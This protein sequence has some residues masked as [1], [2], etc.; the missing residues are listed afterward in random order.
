MAISQSLRSDERMDL[1]SD[2]VLIKGLLPF[3]TLQD[4]TQTVSLLSKRWNRILKTDAVW[5]KHDRTPA[6]AHTCMCAYTSLLFRGILYFRDFYFSHSPK[7]KSSKRKRPGHRGETPVQEKPKCDFAFP[8]QRADLWKPL[9]HQ[10]WRQLYL[11]RYKQLK[12]HNDISFMSQG[13]AAQIALLDLEMA[14]RLSSDSPQQKTTMEG[15]A[16]SARTISPSEHNCGP[17][18]AFAYPL[19]DLAATFVCPISGRLLDAAEISLCRAAN[20]TWDDR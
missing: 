2:C 7:R 20:Q 11:D 10:P 15:D 8:E 17:E 19:E 18:C 12:A 3:L 1:L 14:E 5:Y 4:L 6:C 9:D 16:N 13:R